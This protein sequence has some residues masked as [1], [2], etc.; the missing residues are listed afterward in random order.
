MTDSYF[1][2]PERLAR[3]Y[4]ERLSAGFGPAA[5]RKLA[6]T[7]RDA[8][9]AGDRRRYRFWLLVRDAVRQGIET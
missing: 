1:E 5:E 6:W 4:A 7:L 9:A 3:T 8:E 2:N